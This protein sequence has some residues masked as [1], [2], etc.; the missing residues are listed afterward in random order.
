MR[1]ILCLFLVSCSVHALSQDC[2]ISGTEQ[3]YAG[4]DVPVFRVV[5]PVTGEKTVLD[6]VHFNHDGSFHARFRLE[7]I[8]VLYLELGIY[9]GFLYAA[10]D[11]EY[12]LALPPFMEKSHYKHI[13]PFYKPAEVHLRVSE[14]R[15]INTGVVIPD[16]SELNRLLFRFDTAFNKINRMMIQQRQTRETLHA[17]SVIK[18]LETEF[19]G[20][21]T[22]FFDRYRKYRYG[23]L[24]INERKTDLQGLALHYLNDRMPRL[25]EPAYMDLFNAMFND[26]FYYFSGTR[27]GEHVNAAINRKHSLSLLRKELRKHPAIFSDTIADLVI[28]KEIADQYYKDAYIQDALLI[29]LDSLSQNASVSAYRMMA[30]AMHE[31]YSRLMIGNFPPGFNLRDQ[32]GRYRTMEEF[33]GKYV[34]LFF[35]TPDNYACMMEYPFLKSFHQKHRDYLEIVTIM[36]TEKIEYM[37]EFMKQNHYDWISLF[38]DDQPGI[39]E[40]FNIKIYPSSL[41]IGPDGRLVQSPGTIPSE[42]FQQQL[43]RIMRSRGEI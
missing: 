34:Y 28:L 24:K 2:I 16:H 22:A 13:N 40:Q 21:S 14:S 31:K 27:E 17:D 30:E 20:N 29:L 1:K 12:R 9:E 42:G 23:L 43:F 6:S 19:S 7:D 25:N 11:S 4:L 38:Y 41:L 37:T 26:F 18:W 36:V 35:C 5:N 8:T 3:E 10:P 32:N 39:L 15:D 33:R